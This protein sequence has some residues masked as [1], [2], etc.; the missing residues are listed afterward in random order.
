MGTVVGAVSTATQELAYF[1][2]LSLNR[3]HRLKSESVSVC[4]LLSSTH[5]EHEKTSGLPVNITS[6]PGECGLSCVQG[7]CWLC[8]FV[9]CDQVRLHLSELGLTDTKQPSSSIGGPQL[10]Q[11][12]G[13]R[14]DC[15]VLHHKWA[16][17][18]GVQRQD[19]W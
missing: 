9:E 11:E 7:W 4:S 14:T 8:G 16:K 13:W 6:H 19:V 18:G 15:M 2:T 12:P 17:M 5:G 10:L 1:A 3:R